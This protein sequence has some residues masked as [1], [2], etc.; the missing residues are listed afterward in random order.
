MFYDRA[1]SAKHGVIVARNPARERFLAYVAGDGPMIETLTAGK[2]EP[3]GMA[4]HAARTEDGLVIWR[5]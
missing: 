3:V 2:T 5:A 1:G 4:G